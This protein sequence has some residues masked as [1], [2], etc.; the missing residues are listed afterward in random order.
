MRDACSPGGWADLVPGYPQGG[1]TASR[2]QQALPPYPRHHLPRVKGPPPKGRA[3]AVSRPCTDTVSM[4]ISLATVVGGL[5]LHAGKDVLIHGHRKSR[6]RVSEPLTTFNGT[7][8]RSNSV[9]WVRRRSRSRMRSHPEVRG[10][11]AMCGGSVGHRRDGV[12]STTWPRR[13]RDRS[14]IWPSP[15]RGRGRPR[16]PRIRP[17][18]HP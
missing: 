4:S 6:R 9:A 11:V 8:A 3:W 13:P 10:P 2:R 12:L 16:P 15:R 7:L 1:V 5:A 14:R 18:P 17:R